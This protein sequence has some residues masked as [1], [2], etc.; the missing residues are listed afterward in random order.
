MAAK[1]RGP[2]RTLKARLRVIG[3]GGNR[4]ARRLSSCRK[5]IVVSDVEAIQKAI[6][7]SVQATTPNAA[8]VNACF[9][10][11]GKKT[12]HR[13]LQCVAQAI[14]SGNLTPQTGMLETL[15][16]IGNVFTVIEVK[17]LLSG[18]RWFVVLRERL[19]EL[20]AEWIAL[21]HVAGE[22]HVVIPS[23]FR[24]NT[25]PK[26]LFR[27]TV[28]A[29]LDGDVR[30]IPGAL[31]DDTDEDNEHPS[32]WFPEDENGKDGSVDETSEDDN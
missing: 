4:G 10:D 18:L 8:R 16:K 29:L 24:N 30:G 14:L 27:E 23:E 6:L 3:S 21:H 15:G 25:T 7:A 12:R 28:K 32:E 1:K 19:A 26:R 11:L 9:L 31:E 5:N 22:Q 20:I 13:V 17:R 2:K